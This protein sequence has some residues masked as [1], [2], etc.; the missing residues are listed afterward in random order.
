MG[1]QLIRFDPI[2]REFVW[3]PLPSTGFSSQIDTLMKNIIHSY[4]N[5]AK[6][7]P[8]TLI[9]QGI[10]TLQRKIQGFSD[11]AECVDSAFDF[12]GSLQFPSPS[13]GIGSQ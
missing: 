6:Y 9:L 2:G 12:L 8:Q 10:D 4:Q 7:T 1:F 13:R 3:E 5:F 11:L